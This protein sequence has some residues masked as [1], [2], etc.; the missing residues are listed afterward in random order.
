MSQYIDF[1]VK[2]EIFNTAALARKIGVARSNL[3]RR[4]KG[5]K[6]ISKEKEAELESYIRDVF[7]DFPRKI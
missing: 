3:N 7:D 4:L 6:T 1:I 5:D 2:H